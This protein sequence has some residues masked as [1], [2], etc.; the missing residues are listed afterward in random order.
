MEFWSMFLAIPLV[1][2]IVLGVIFLAGFIR[3]S[4]MIVYIGNDSMGIVEKL[5]SLKGSVTEGFLSLEGNA[6][7]QPELLRGGLHLFPPFQYRI[8]VQPLPMVPQ[9]TI[10][11]V[12]ARSGQPL[13]PG[14]ALA[15][16]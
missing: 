2:R 13:Y 8:H 5:W 3:L 10:G 14:Q 4:R 7:F 16:L 11:Y 9:G 12:F 1:I 6:G 15:S